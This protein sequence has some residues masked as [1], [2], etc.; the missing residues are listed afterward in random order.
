MAGKTKY[1]NWLPFNVSSNGAKINEVIF[2][3]HGQKRGFQFTA[4]IEKKKKK[5][6]LTRVSDFDPG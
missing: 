6:N 2:N 1:Q 4:A 5:Q 3:P